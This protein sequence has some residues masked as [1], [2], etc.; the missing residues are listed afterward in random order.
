[1]ITLGVTDLD[2]S[3]AFYE[4]IFAK[5]RSRHSNDGIVFIKLIGI[6]LAL[7]RHKSLARDAQVDPSG[8][9]FRGFTLSYNAR[10]ESEVDE[11]MR[12][13][14]AAGGRTTKKP[15]KGTWGLYNSYFSDPDGNMFEV[16]YNPVFP[17]LENGELDI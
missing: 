6:V 16:V 13:V 17:M 9:G 15:Q 10:S 2:R 8:S 1:M 5:K 11:M 7:F 3:A 4:T 12:Y 14:E